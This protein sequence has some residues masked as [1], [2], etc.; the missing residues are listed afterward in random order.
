MVHTYEESFQEKYGKAS[1]PM[2][3]KV[4]EAVRANGDDFYVYYSAY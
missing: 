1:D 3:K 4:E 2:H